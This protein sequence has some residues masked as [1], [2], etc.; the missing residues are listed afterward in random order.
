[1][2]LSTVSIFK[3]ID[4]ENNPDL[5]VVSDEELHKLQGTLFEMLEEIDAFCQKNHIA[6][7]L[8]GG[9]A[10]GAVR[11]GGFIP[12]DDDVDL[13]MSRSDYEKLKRCFDSQ[14]GNRFWFS[15]NQKKR[16]SL[17]IQRG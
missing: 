16:D 14:M 4:V 1:M 3:N 9:S 7:T 6:Y 2:G 5:K 17:P 12:W 8:A 13:L 11:H 15:T 10:L